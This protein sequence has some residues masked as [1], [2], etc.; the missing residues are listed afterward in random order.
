MIQS[1]SVCVFDNKYNYLYDLPES[2]WF[3]E[4]NIMFGLYS[5]LNYKGKST[6]KKGLKFK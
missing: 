6:L 1:G 3:G 5:S 2:S 4:Y